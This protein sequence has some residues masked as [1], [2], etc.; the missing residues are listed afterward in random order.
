MNVGITL[1]DQ[2]FEP[3]MIN[4]ELKNENFIREHKLP[5]IARYPNKDLVTGSQE[6]Q[7]MFD[8]FRAA[9]CIKT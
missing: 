9:T 5:L 2:S 8:I 3:E 7:N 6:Y 1:Q 4:L